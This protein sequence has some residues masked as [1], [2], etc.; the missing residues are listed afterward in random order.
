MQY[1]AKCAKERK[2]MCEELQKLII[3]DIDNK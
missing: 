2:Q 1:A 3:E